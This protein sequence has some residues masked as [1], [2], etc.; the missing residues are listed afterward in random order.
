MSR[1]RNLL[2]GLGIGSALALIG[3]LAVTKPEDRT[4]GGLIINGLAGALSGALIQKK[5]SSAIVGGIS[6]LGSYLVSTPIEKRN[7]RGF[8]LSGSIGAATGLLTANL[9]TRRT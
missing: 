6:G 4:T 1:N 2:V 9:T 7:G 5:K 3:Y 8:L